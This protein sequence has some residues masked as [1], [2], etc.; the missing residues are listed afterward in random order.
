MGHRPILK[1]QA[2]PKGV[3]M[4]SNCQPYPMALN[5][6]ILRELISLQWVATLIDYLVVGGDECAHFCRM[7]LTIENV[8]KIAKSLHF[9]RPPMHGK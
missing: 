6:V 8:T 9:M 2:C 7:G 3:P 4:V 1:L 5:L